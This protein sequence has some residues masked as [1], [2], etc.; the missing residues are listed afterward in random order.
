MATCCFCWITTYAFVIRPLPTLTSKHVMIYFGVFFKMQD[1]VWTDKNVINGHRAI[2]DPNKAYPSS[3]LTSKLN[4]D[5]TCGLTGVKLSCLHYLW[6]RSRKVA[7]FSKNSS[8]QWSEGVTKPSWSS[9]QIEVNLSF[10]GS[11]WVYFEQEIVFKY[12]QGMNKPLKSASK[13][14]KMLKSR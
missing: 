12:F 2:Y 9:E 8:A 7:W 14:K 6:Q 13:V 4:P 11:F 1:I 5:V 3:L 10:F